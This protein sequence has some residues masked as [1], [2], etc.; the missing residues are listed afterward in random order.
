MSAP[1]GAAPPPCAAAPAGNLADA[2]AGVEENVRVGVHEAIF[3]GEESLNRIV[4]VVAGEAYGG[5]ME[6]GAGQALP[7]PPGP[8]L[9]PSVSSTSL[10][11]GLTLVAQ[12]QIQQGE[13]TAHSLLAGGGPQVRTAR[14]EEAYEEAQVV[15]GHQGLERQMEGVLQ[16]HSGGQR[17]RGLGPCRSRGWAGAPITPGPRYGQ[18]DGQYSPFL[19]PPHPRGGGGSLRGGGR[20]R[21]ADSDNRGARRESRLCRSW[22]IGAGCPLPEKAGPLSVEG[23]RETPLILAGSWS[24]LLAS[25]LHPSENRALPALL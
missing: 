18:E 2:A 1:D 3:E 13:D 14:G 9:C 10:R 15:E 11:P 19:A 20:V 5:R 17:R 16:R 24:R 21:C 6:S 7:Q 12:L 8:R 4:L 22:R 25:H 23:L